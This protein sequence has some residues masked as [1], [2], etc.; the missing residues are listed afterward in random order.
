MD[1]GLDERT[2]RRIIALLVSFAGL[3]D[4][5]AGR[6][7]PVRWLVLAILRYAQRVALGYLAETTGMDWAACFEEDTGCRPDDDALLAGRFRTLAELLGALLPPDNRFDDS[8]VWTTGRD[9]AQHAFA[10]RARLNL[11][12]SG[13]WP[14]QAPDTS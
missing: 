7:F 11:A 2:L 1:L 9:G 14:H 8:D 5:A 10:L 6:S 3:A 13:G 12:A 4:R